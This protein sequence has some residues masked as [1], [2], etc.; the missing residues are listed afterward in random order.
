MAQALAKHLAARPAEWFAIDVAGVKKPPED[1]LPVV[2]VLP[3]KGDYFVQSSLAI[4]PLASGATVA[5][6]G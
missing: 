1:T 6:F 3:V 5:F 4:W 2:S